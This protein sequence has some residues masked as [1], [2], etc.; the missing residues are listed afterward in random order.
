MTT[1]SPAARAI[2]SA[3]LF[4]RPKPLP[5]TSD[6]HADPRR[7][8]LEDAILALLKQHYPTYLKLRGPDIRWSLNRA[9]LRFV[10]ERVRG[11]QTRTA[12][13]AGMNRNTVRRLLRIFTRLAQLSER[14]RPAIERAAARSSLIRERGAARGRDEADRG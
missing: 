9:F 5:P 11:S 13:T 6:A 2:G 10:L 7:A 1:T 14:R 4:T 8:L 3:I 12:E